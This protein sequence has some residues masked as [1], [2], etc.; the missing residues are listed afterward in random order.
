MPNLVRCKACGFVIREDRL[1]DVCPACG[2]PRSSFE[3]YKEKVS[4]KRQKILDMHLHPVLVHFPEAFGIFILILSAIGFIATG[5][6]RA[7]LLCAIPLLA[8]F[9]PIF[10]V[11]AILSGVLDGKTRFKKLDTP[12][13]KKKIIFGTVFLGL[14]IILAIGSSI[15]IYT[16]YGL[17][18]VFSLSLACVLVGGILGLIGGS[19]LEAKLPN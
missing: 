4:E 3:P 19:L 6:F 17:I 12:H 9:L 14:S 8:I 5:G 10:A 16:P 7:V 2:V 18:F 13:L 11:F 1:G 15:M